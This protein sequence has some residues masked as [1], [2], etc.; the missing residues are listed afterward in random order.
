MGL[1]IT[2][3]GLKEGCNFGYFTHG[4]FCVQLAYAAY[5]EKMGRLFEEFLLHR[6]EMQEDDIK[7]WNAHCDDGLDLL[8]Y[9]SDCDGKLSPKECRAVYEA[10]KDLSLPMIAHNY[11]DASSEQYNL[12]ERW[13][14]MLKHCIKRRVNLYFS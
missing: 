2:A 4:R 5:D 10:I 12:L 13:K 9:H 11:G 3:T 14:T 6:V 7:F 8:L 1:H